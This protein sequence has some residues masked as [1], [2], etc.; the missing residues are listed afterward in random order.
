MSRAG[1]GLS[2]SGQTAF[3]E[4]RERRTSSCY[5][6]TLLLMHGH[7]VVQAVEAKHA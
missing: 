1:R 4:Q 2:A 3:E 6:R 7:T 5:P